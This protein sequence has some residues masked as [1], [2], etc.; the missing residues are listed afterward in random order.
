M[1]KEITAQASVDHHYFTPWNNGAMQSMTHDVN[2]EPVC[3][4]NDN[5]LPPTGPQQ[6]NFLPEMPSYVSAA[7]AFYALAEMP[8]DVASQISVPP[9]PNNWSGHPNTWRQS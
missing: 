5:L 6:R 9:G 8:G 3:S 1:T 2:P 4:Y 7:S